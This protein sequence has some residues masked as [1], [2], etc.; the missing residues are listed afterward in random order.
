ML[1]PTLID[2]EKSTFY[3]GFGKKGGENIT[4]RRQEIDEKAVT[5]LNIMTELILK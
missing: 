2:R 1:L 4:N 3:V 5:K